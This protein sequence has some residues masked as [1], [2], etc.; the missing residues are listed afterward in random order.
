M[1]KD[2][3][4]CL[5][6]CQFRMITLFF[7]ILIQKISDAL[8]LSGDHSL[9]QESPAMTTSNILKTAVL[10]CSIVQSTPAGEMGNG[11]CTRPVRI[12]LMPGY[13]SSFL[14]R[15]VKKLV[16]PET[17]GFVSQ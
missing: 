7:L 8:Q 14:R 5:Y 3:F 15:L 16:V 9:G 10:L 11:F 12:V 4:T 1:M 2:R 6:R 13:H 17:N